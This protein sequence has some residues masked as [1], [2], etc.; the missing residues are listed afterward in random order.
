MSLDLNG[1]VFSRILC[2]VPDSK[3][4]YSVLRALPKSH[5]WFSIG[6]QRVCELPVYLDTFD[7][8]S[9][10]ASNQVLDYLLDQNDN[11]NFTGIAESIRHLVV[12][13]EHSKYFWPPEPD[14]E[15]EEDEEAQE[16]EEETELEETDQEEETEKEEDDQQVV[17]ETSEP[18]EEEE[19]EPEVEVD[20]VAFHDRLPGLLQKTRNLRSLDYHS[21]PGLP[22][23]RESVELL[24]ACERLE[25]LGVDS[26]IRETSW[27]GLWAYE[28]PE[29]WE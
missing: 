29:T 27:Q 9:A 25:T 20:V 22:L 7:P 4:I 11:A 13:V 12:A 17:D 26:S 6:L 18:A 2:H 1:D 3:S 28:D 14:V 19:E 10:A 24:A 23:S 8:G 16:L 5:P 15:A 21:C